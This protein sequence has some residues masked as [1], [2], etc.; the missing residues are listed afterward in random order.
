MKNCKFEKIRKLKVKDLCVEYAKIKNLSVVENSDLNIVN[1]QT[2]NVKGTSTLN[3][4][5]LQSLNVKGNLTLENADL[6]NLNVTTI[7]GLNVKCAQSFNNFNSPIVEIEYINDSPVK[8]INPGNFNQI[9]WDGLW[10]KTLA[11]HDFLET[12]LFSGRK[13]IAD[14]NQAASCNICPAEETFVPLTIFGI[15]SVSPIKR[16]I[17]GPSIEEQVTQ[18]IST[19]TYN[20]DVTN[21]TDNLAIRAL[22]IL[23]QFGWLDKDKNFVY[24][25]VD[26]AIRQFGASLNQNYGEK[27]TGTVI[28]PTQE[29][30]DIAALMPYDGNSAAIQMVVYQEEGLIIDLP[31]KFLSRNTQ[32][33]NG[34]VDT[35]FV[36][37]SVGGQLQWA[38]AYSNYSYTIDNIVSLESSFR[39]SSSGPTTQW[40]M[41]WQF[42]GPPAAEGGGGGYFGVNTNGDGEF[43]VLG[44]IFNVALSSVAGQSFVTPVKFGGEGEGWSL[45]IL[46]DD[47]S[48]FPITLDTNY[49]LRLN[50]Q[51]LINNQA[52][53]EFIIRN[54]DTS[55]SVNLGTINTS[56]SYSFI[57]KTGVY[58]FSEYFG[59]GAPNVMCE[60]IP[61]SIITWTFPK[62]NDIPN[63]ATYIPWVPPPQLCGNYKIEPTLPNG[64]VVMTFGGVI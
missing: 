38:N 31:K 53:W 3:D 26:L 61:Q 6:N 62:V 8:P 24:E 51:N 52:V 34:P 30:R 64:P 49:T 11:D 15:Q 5:N 37:Q 16:I 36:G 48:N 42:I 39:L 18:L 56:S 59:P 28:L 55:T 29:I 50:R 17:C 63:S 25:E 47:I 23:I 13:R 10:D 9:V 33:T 21:A 58:Q 40:V 35:Q 46:P 14:I 54:D 57:D 1:A 60:T 2:L 20:F 32:S 43:Q 4:V 44:S 27:Y 22:I 7:N 12:D 45:R 19:I 41:G